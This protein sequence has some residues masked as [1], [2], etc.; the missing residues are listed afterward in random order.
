MIINDRKNIS[1][2]EQYFNI[3]E[4]QQTFITAFDI[5]NTFIHLLYGNNY[6]SIKYKTPVDYGPKSPFGNSLFTKI[7]KKN[8][9][10]KNYRE[11]VDYVCE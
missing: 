4:N 8:R 3:Y 2:K 5:Y 11:M 9:T 1:Y 6:T 7:D 10:T